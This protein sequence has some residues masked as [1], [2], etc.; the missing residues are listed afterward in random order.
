[1]ARGANAPVGAEMTSQNGYHYTKT[2][3][4]WKATS[5]IIA[6]KE[7]LHRPLQP[8]ERVG[9]RNGNK[10]DF[11]PENL[12]VTKT[13]TGLDMMKRRRDALIVRIEELQ[14]QLQDLEEDISREE[15]KREV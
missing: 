6:E 10:L 12:V 9:F 11:R 13:K 7:I 8:N 3:D 14:A 2:E 15:L 4:G 5:R 1:M